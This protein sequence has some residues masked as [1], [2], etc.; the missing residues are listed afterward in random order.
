MESKIEKKA[1]RA[2]ES[3]ECSCSFLYS[4]SCIMQGSPFDVTTQQFDILGGAA[5]NGGWM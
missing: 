4:E 3:P 2:Y 1:R 5:E